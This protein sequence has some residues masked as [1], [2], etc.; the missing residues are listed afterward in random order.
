MEFRLFHA[1]QRRH[2][3]AE[4]ICV[5]CEDREGIHDYITQD[6]QVGWLYCI[7][8]EIVLPDGTKRR[9]SNEKDGGFDDLMRA[10]SEPLPL[11]AEQI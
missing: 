6:M 2:N 10:V 5:T 1:I 8:L 3:V 7:I 4:P 9:Y 11:R